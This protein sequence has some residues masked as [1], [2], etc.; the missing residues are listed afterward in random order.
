MRLKNSQPTPTYKREDFFFYFYQRIR[1]FYVQNNKITKRNEN[2]NCFLC[3][4]TV[5]AKKKTLTHT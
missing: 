5:N 3:K 4:S 1:Y 2:G